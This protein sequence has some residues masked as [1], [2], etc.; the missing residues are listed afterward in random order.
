MSS[1]IVT[2]IASAIAASKYPCSGPALVCLP[3]GRQITREEHWNSLNEL[4][5]QV[6]LGYAYAAYTEIGNIGISIVM[7]AAAKSYWSEK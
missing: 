7:Q 2:Q 3:D 4:Y 5:K 1:E 6:Y